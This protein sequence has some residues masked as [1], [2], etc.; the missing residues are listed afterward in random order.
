VDPQALSLFS[1]DG[2]EAWLSTQG[3]QGVTIVGILGV[4]LRLRQVHLR[5]GQGGALVEQHADLIVFLFS[6]VSEVARVIF[7]TMVITP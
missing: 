3:A 5:L 2:S 1:R 6:C 4:L 7:F